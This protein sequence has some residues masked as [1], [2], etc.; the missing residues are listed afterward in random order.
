MTLNDHYEKAKEIYEQN[1]ECLVALFVLQNPHLRADQI[2]LVYQ[3]GILED[4][5]YV[6]ERK[7]D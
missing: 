4:T 5:F 1:K 3:A 7:Y 2:E 6:R